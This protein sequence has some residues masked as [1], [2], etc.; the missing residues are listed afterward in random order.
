MKKFTLSLFTVFVSTSL[1]AQTVSTFESLNLAADSFWNGSDLSGGFSNGNAFFANDYDTAF[2]SWSGFSYSTMKDST[3]AGWGNQY[4]AITASGY[5]AS[6]TYVV[7]DEYGNAKISLTGSAAGKLVEGFYVTNATYAYLSMRDGDLFSKKFGGTTGADEDWFKLTVKGWLNGSLKSNAVEFYLADFRSADST[8]DYIVKDWRWVNLQPLGN[9]DSLQ[10]FLASSDTGQWGMN[11]PAYFCIDN[12]T[13]ADVANAAP[14]AAN[15]FVSV[16][17]D[18]DTLISVLANDFDTTAIPLTVTV[19]NG[20]LIPGATATVDGNG[21]ILYTP[22]IGV[23][24]VD[25]IDYSVCDGE[26]LCGTARVIVNVQSLTGVEEVEVATVS[27]FPNPFNGS[28]NIRLNEAA[29]LVQLLDM[30]G[31]VMLENTLTGN[32]VS[33]NTSDLAAG[34]YFVKVVTAHSTFA[35]RIVKQ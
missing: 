29:Q 6:S 22:A 5:N 13:T 33:L 21:N 35:K 7:A 12:F 34:P 9:V 3:T 27:A 10:F 17:Y 20:P 8:E 16:W 1:I 2:F 18:N 19:T 32:E 31:R 30:N 24:A 14:V 25:T 23:V 4:S 11:T 28:L 15:D 26:G